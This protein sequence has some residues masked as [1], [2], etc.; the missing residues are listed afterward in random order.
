[1]DI[2]RAEFAEN[3]VHYQAGLTFITHQLRMMSAAVQGTQS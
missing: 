2:E 1:M 3:A